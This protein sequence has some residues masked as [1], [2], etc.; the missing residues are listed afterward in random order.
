MV[1]RGITNAPRRRVRVSRE[2]GKHRWHGIGGWSNTCLN[3]SLLHDNIVLSTAMPV[4]SDLSR[5]TLKHKGRIPLQR[6]KMTH[7]HVEEQ[8]I[9]IETVFLAALIVLGALDNKILYFEQIETEGM[10]GASRVLSCEQ[11][12]YIKQT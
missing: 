7:V 3:H 12:L 11:L 5:Q 6:A 4:T 1:P 2:P 9:S 10:T 8:Q